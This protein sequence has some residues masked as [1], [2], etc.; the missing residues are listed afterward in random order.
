MFQ[1]RRRRAGKYSQSPAVE[2]G[3]GNQH[4]GREGPRTT[5]PVNSNMEQIV[6]GSETRKNGDSES[7]LLQMLKKIKQSTGNLAVEVLGDYSRSAPDVRGSP[8]LRRLW[9]VD[10]KIWFGHILGW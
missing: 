3:H 4:Q 6:N 8:R 9:N 2:L 1:E 7:L 10:I 5:C